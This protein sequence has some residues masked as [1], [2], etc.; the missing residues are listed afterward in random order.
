MTA[1]VRHSLFTSLGSVF[2]R[3]RLDSKLVIGVIFVALTGLV[4]MLV[5]LSSIIVPQFDLLEQQEVARHRERTEAALNE[6]AMRVETTVRD[7]GAWNESFDYIQRPTREFERDTFSLLALTNLDVSGMAYIRF[8][9]TVMFGRWVDLEN[10]I[11]LQKQSRE[12]EALLTEP[13]VLA[14][15]RKRASLRYYGWVGD[16]LAAISTAQVVRTDGSGKPAGFV[17]MAREIDSAGLSQLIQ[18]D[19]RLVRAGDVMPALHAGDEETI[20]RVSVPVRGLDKRIVATADFGVRRDLTAMGFQTLLVALAAAALVMLFALIVLS[21]L[22]RH[23]AIKPMRRVER[24]M[25]SIAL[26]G[27]LSPLIEAERLD[28]LGSLVRNYNLMLNQLKDLRE[29]LEIQSFRLGRTESAVGL[30]HNVRNG[31]NPVSIILNQIANSEPPVAREDVQRAL[32]ELKGGTGDESR[33]RR[34]ASFVDA[35]V[36]AQSQQINAYAQELEAARTHLTRVVELIGDQ[37]AVAHQPVEAQAC[38][39]RSV[40]EQ[41]AALARYSSIG[42]I[43]FDVPETLGHALANR[44]LL[45]QIIGNLFGNAVESIQSAG[46]SKGLIEIGHEYLEALHGPCVKITIRDN[47]EGFE[48][49]MDKSFFEQ[50]YST[51]NHKSGGLGL[52][53][54]AHAV[55]MMQGELSLTSDGKGLGAMATIT[56]PAVTLPAQSVQD[57][58]NKVAQAA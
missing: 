33:R 47:G 20:R 11:E 56:L 9:G 46:R 1:R 42:D 14:A 54:C 58:A 52:H 17:V 36:L 7:Y 16:K 51:R 3:A 57:D 22:V 49:G 15:A 12:F 44:V 50:G 18:M 32:D 34:L 4:A 41:N 38:D 28:E 40:I 27:D 23:F 6:Y 24:H 19:A 48:T 10:Q 2:D 25:Q 13:A 55:K 21:R 31:L 53:W 8:D 45:S 26:S 43:R 35:T 37:Q 30:M 5:A 39:I 29:Q